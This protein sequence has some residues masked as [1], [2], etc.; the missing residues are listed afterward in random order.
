MRYLVPGILDNSV[1]TA[2]ILDGQVGTNDLAAD[3]VTAAKIGS[4]I[5]ILGDTKR[6]M[7]N[8]G[9]DSDQVISTATD[10][11]I[12]WNVAGMP[13]STLHSE[14]SNTD[15]FVVPSGFTRARIT[16]GATFAA[17]GT[18]IRHLRITQNATD[19]N[20]LPKYLEPVPSAT[21]PTYMIVTSGWFSVSAADII[22]A[23]VHQTSGGNLN[24]TF[25][26]KLW[27]M[28]EVIG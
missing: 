10:T 20:N 23:L 21:Q 27:A 11:A 3:A 14:S 12:L 1:T 4:E 24:L 22:R 13:E 28:F 26:E 9:R 17:N 6:R 15:R 8:V 16:V 25:T 19:I 5:I 7:C 2:K 18:G